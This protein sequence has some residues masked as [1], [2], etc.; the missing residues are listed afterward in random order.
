[1]NWISV[2][3]RFSLKGKNKPIGVTM[4]D[5]AF[6]KEKELT[7]DVLV[8]VIAARLAEFAIKTSFVKS[9]EINSLIQKA[10]DQVKT[11]KFE[12]K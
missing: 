10:G 7:F 8:A 9:D 12:F 3:A 11:I 2:S 1:M 5:W 4:E 6:A